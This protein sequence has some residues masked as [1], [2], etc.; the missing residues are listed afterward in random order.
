MEEE[1]IKI[2]DILHVLRERWKLI[3][4]ITSLTT[5]FSAVFSFCVI[6]P[7]YESTTKLFIGK[8]ESSTSEYSNND[9]QM[10]Q[11]L[12]KT[13]A[14]V[15]KTKDLVDS[16]LSGEYALLENED[17]EDEIGVIQSQSIPLMTK[18]VL[19][20]LTV[21]S[22]T[23]TQIL[24]I[25][26]TSTSPEEAAD[27]VKAITS[28][29]ILKSKEL[30]PNGNVQVIEEAQIAESPVSPNKKMNIAIAFVLGLMISIGLVFLLEYLDNSF[31]DKDTLENVLDLPVIGVI[32]NTK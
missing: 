14:E 18:D 6:K 10:Y 1:V 26:Y 22:S 9:I 13:Y 3:V 32:P 16:A 15:I 17:D 2:E 29:F 20:N 31:K 30:I 28:V 21:T 11:K 8:E 27:V 25:E 12:M 5:L 23:D 4:I 7:K 24:E 19:E